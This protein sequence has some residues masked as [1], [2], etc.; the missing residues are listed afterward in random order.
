MSNA[1]CVT[2]A[3]IILVTWQVPAENLVGS[4]KTIPGILLIHFEVVSLFANQ[5]I[6]PLT[7]LDVGRLIYGT[8]PAPTVAHWRIQL[9]KA[10]S[11][12]QNR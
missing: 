4:V 5:A 7:A 12:K 3:L 8:L 10:K 6:E 11:K 9:T 1:C 2:S